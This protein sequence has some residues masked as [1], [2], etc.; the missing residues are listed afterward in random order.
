MGTLLIGWLF[1]FGKSTYDMGKEQG[2][3]DG[4][5]SVEFKYSFRGDT[6]Y[7]NTSHSL[8]TIMPYDHKLKV[9]EDY[10]TCSM[11]LDTLKI[12]LFK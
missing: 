4:R 10:S 8:E 3:S 9:T 12:Q 1:L 7:I 5:K 2:Y 11:K 6:F